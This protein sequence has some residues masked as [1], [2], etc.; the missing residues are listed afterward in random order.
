MISISI[1]FGN[2]KLNLLVA[3]I[4]FGVYCWYKR[5]QVSEE[6]DVLEQ[7]AKTWILLTDPKCPFCE[8]QLEVLGPKQG[9]FRILDV[10]KDAKLIKKLKLPTGKGVPC[11]I[12]TKTKKYQV[13]LLQLD[14]I[15]RL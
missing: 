1:G 7:V 5:Q 2:W 6:T 14:D 3:I 9:M 8:K 15:K 12:N 10:R 4:A 13:G 11:W